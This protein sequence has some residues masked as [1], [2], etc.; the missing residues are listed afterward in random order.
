M[1]T[2]LLYEE[3]KLHE[4]TVPPS[5]RL[6]HV[7]A[8]ALGAN[9]VGKVLVDVHSIEVPLSWTVGLCKKLYRRLS[10]V[11]RQR[12]STLP[13]SDTV[14]V[15][16]HDI[17]DKLLPEYR[18]FLDWICDGRDEYRSG[19]GTIVKVDGLLFNKSKGEIVSLSD[20]QD[21]MINMVVAGEDDAHLLLMNELHTDFRM[22]TRKDAF[23]TVSPPYF[24][25]TRVQNNTKSLAVSR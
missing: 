8:K 18:S 1:Q 6:R 14:V 5:T 11:V 3:G 2:V 12:I 22:Y 16:L 9:R 21:D 4:I 20:R 7:I 13:H 24:C 19:F 23:T 15:S 25:K 17:H 10:F